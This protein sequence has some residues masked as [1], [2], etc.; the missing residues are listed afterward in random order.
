[1]SMA[2]AILEYKIS[3]LRNFSVLAPPC[4][5]ASKTALACSCWGKSEEP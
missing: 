3:L 2:H 5:G 1:M 4:C